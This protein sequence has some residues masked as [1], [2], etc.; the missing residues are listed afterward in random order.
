MLMARDGRVTDT[1]PPIPF[2][3]NQWAVLREGGGGFFRSQPFADGPLWSFAHDERALVI[4]NREAPA[5]R[6]GATFSVSKLDFPGDTMFSVVVA[7]EPVPIDRSEA[8][9]ILDAVGTF[10]VEG[11]GFAA[12]PE[13]GRQMAAATLYL[14][15]FHPGVTN[16]R[17]ARDGGIWVSRRPDESGTEWLAMDGSGLLLGRVTLPSR[18]NPLVIDPPLL[19]GSETDDL[20]VPY[21][22]RY[23]VSQ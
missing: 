13:Q 1:L 12:S 8:D 18:V 5:R 3:R 11:P 7:F 19:W 21:V 20:D 2:G 10:L 17:I 23:R 4:V 9:S 16:L 14:P 6:D 22:V 15:A